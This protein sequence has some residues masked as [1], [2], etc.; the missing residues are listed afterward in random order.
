MPGYL[1]SLI[2]VIHVNCRVSEFSKVSK[3]GHYFTLKTR[4][5]IKKNHTMEV[6]GFLITINVPVVYMGRYEVV[7]RG[8]YQ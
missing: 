1:H 4:C 2:S 7:F 3:S 5:Q 8:D 6:K